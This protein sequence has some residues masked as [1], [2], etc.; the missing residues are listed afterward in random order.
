MP[1]LVSQKWEEYS[2]YFNITDSWSGKVKND[3]RH[4]EAK[5]ISSNNKMKLS[6]FTVWLKF[7]LP[8]H[9]IKVCCIVSW[10]NYSYQNDHKA[11]DE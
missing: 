2:P 11:N 6:S 4:G 1:N 5:Y 9:D 8:L 7:D 3:M 10:H